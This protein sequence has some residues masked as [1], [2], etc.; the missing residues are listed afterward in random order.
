M[1]VEWQLTGTYAAEE[2]GL[3]LGQFNT[4][5]QSWVDANPSDIN[6]DG[7]TMNIAF[8]TQTY[9]VTYE[10]QTNIPASDSLLYI[11]DIAF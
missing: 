5:V 9:I 10:V 6:P 4:A 11:V 8:N 3:D 1:Q 2:L 7:D